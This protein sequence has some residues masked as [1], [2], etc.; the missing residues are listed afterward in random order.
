M[1]TAKLDV[2]TM[3][4]EDLMGLEARIKAA[5]AAKAVDYQNEL[6]VRYQALRDEMISNGVVTEDQLP[7]LKKRG[8]KRGGKAG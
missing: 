1:A 3:S 5:K 8:W 4:M 2:E 6:I 7:R